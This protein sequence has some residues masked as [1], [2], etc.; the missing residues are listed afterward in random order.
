MTLQDLTVT[1]ALMKRSMQLLRGFHGNCSLTIRPDCGYRG[2]VR[3]LPVE[4][5]SMNLLSV[6]KHVLPP[7]AFREQ[8]S[9]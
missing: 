9:W 6:C 7:E 3:M 4:L 1:E 5:I 2:H 8:E